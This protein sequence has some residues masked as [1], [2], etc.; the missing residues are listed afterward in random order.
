[1]TLRLDEF[2]GDGC[3]V[4]R[5]EV[6]IARQWRAIRLDRETWCGKPPSSDVDDRAPNLFLFSR[7]AGP[8]FEST[9]HEAPLPPPPQSGRDLQGMVS[10]GKPGQR[11][12]RPSD[13]DAGMIRVVPRYSGNRRAVLVFARMFFIHKE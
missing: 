11:P 3:P 6:R 1:M 9:V 2:W 5:R 13:F 10:F 7:E 8:S 12:S 4:F